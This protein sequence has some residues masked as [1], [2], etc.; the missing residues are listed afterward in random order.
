MADKVEFV[1][2]L[3]A[4]FNVLEKHKG[5]SSAHTRTAKFLAE[6]VD[7]GL[8]PLECAKELMWK[9]GDEITKSND[10]HYSRGYADG[11]YEGE[12]VYFALD[13]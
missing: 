3:N 1:D 12:E 8:M 11:Y 5:D 9:I 10:Y 13:C 6:A 2:A 7:D 4:I